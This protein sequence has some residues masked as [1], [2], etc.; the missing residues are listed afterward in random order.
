MPC[1]NCNQTAC[2][3]C[4]AEVHICNQ[5]P[6]EQP[7]DCEVKD[8]STDCI[9]YDQDDIICNGVVVV[10]KNTILSDALNKIVDWACTRLSD[11]QNFFVI[12]NVGAGAKVFKQTNLIGEKE[13]R[14]ITSTNNSVIIT[15]GVDTI[16]LAVASS[17]ITDVCITSL[18]NTVTIVEEEGCFDLSV[19]NPPICITSTKNTIAITENNGCYDLDV[20]I[21]PPIEL[22]NGVTTI[23]NGDGQVTPYSTEIVNLQKVV[24]TFPYTLT[25]ADDKYSIFINNGATDIIINVP[26]GLVNNFTCVFIQ[27][28]LGD[29]TIQQ[30]GSATVLYPSTLQNKIK[31]QNYWAMV[32]KKQATNNY[33][34]LG[35]LMPI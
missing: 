18:D 32:E 7:C 15:E 12:K 10:P 20:T 28:G 11:I 33:F 6:T 8:L 2:N 31:G 5:C 21:D 19:E 25:S 24:S 22:Q 29:V 1:H 13:L 17:A 30:S 26:N 14:T 34:L 3:G 9:I 4:Q 35:S 27:E 23:V 16:N